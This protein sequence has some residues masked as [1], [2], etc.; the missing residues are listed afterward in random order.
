MFTRQ[1]PNIGTS[2]LLG[3][4]SAPQA[5]EMQNLLG[6][7]RQTLVHR[8]PV[9]LDYTRPN[10]RLITPELAKFHFPNFRFDPPEVPR[11]KKPDEDPPPD[12]APDEPL[13]PDPEAPEDPQDPSDPQYEYTAGD[14]IDI[15]NR[16]VSLKHNDERR[17]CVFPDRLNVNNTVNSVEFKV[18]LPKN[19]SEA[20]GKNSSAIKL[21]IEEKPRETLWK[22][23]YTLTEITYIKNVRLD[24]SNMRLYFE[25]GTA[26]VFDP[27]DA[28]PI[29][30]PLTTCTTTTPNPAILI[31]TVNPGSSD[32]TG[33][34]IDILDF[35][36]SFTWVATYTPSG[37]TTTVF[38]KPPDRGTLHVPFDTT[39]IT[40]TASKDGWVTATKTLTPPF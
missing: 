24:L 31:D 40:I 37:A 18:V 25:R 34:Y 5:S 38:A 22:L 10:M 30:I 20:L 33:F 15:T 35:D 19:V 13:G 12:V 29:L 27:K 32:A 2:L 26:K 9:E 3:G 36:A 11:K 28:E 1:A 23:D 14:Y 17:H 16:T 7:C 4:L 21:S 6:N 39:S 8:G